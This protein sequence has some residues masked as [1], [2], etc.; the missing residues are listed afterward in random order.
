MAVQGRELKHLKALSQ[1]VIQQRSDIELFLLSSL[2]M[3]R[4]PYICS[5]CDTAS[6]HPVFVFCSRDAAQA[7]S[8]CSS[9][10][11]RGGKGTQRPPRSCS[12]GNITSG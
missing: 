6:H 7:R 8:S 11:S 10:A 1:A 9:G 2:E 4:F 5:C 3:V 12:G